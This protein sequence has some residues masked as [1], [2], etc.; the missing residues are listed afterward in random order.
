MLSE[1]RGF[2]RYGKTLHSQALLLLQTPET[3]MQHNFIKA[4]EQEKWKHPHPG[5]FKRNL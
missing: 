2:S 1:K 3:G 5:W 4:G